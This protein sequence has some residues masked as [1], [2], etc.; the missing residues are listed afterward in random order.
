MPSEIEGWMGRK[1]RKWLTKKAQKYNKIIEVGV[2]KGLTTRILAE[3][4]RGTVWAVDTWKGTPHDPE[5]HHLYQE[6]DTT[7]VYAEFLANMGNYVTLGKVIPVHSDSVSAAEMLFN[8]YGRIFD[9]V[10][11]DADHSYDGC[12]CDIRSYLRLVRRGGMIAGHD[13]NKPAFPGVKQAVDEIF[14]NS[15]K[16]GPASIWTVRV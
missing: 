8:E 15:V 13:Y 10:F 4:T 16:V 7:D 12:L 14:G 11:I 9:F 1:P 3:N 2:W 5:Q 6:A